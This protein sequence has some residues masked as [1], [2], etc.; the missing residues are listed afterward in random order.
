MRP[1]LKAALDRA[2]ALLLAFAAGSAVPL[3]GHA[4]TAVEPGNGV[5]AAADEAGWAEAQRARTAEAYQRYLELFPTGAH[6]E[7]AFRRLI[8][9]SFDR[10]PVGRLVDLEPPILPWGTPTERVVVAADLALY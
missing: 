3:G 4:Q 1:A 10:Q 2:R 5:S 8:E 9:R 6:A 7:E